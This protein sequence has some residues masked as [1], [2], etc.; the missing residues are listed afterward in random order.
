MTA[1][2]TVGARLI[3][4]LTEFAEALKSGEPLETRLTGSDA[5]R[6]SKRGERSVPP[7]RRPLVV[8]TTKNKTK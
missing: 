1:K 7:R 8:R 5:N 3:E 4:G 2:K 6:R